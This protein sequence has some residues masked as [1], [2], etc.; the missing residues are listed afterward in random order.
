MQVLLLVL[1]GA[2]SMPIN[3]EEVTTELAITTIAS[4]IDTTLAQDETLETTTVSTSGD[5]HSLESPSQTVEIRLHPQL[6]HTDQLKLTTTEA[7]S[8]TWTTTSAL[9][10]SAEEFK[11]EDIKRETPKGEPYSIF[12]SLSDR[13][14]LK[15]S[16]G[17]ALR[18]A[19]TSSPVVHTLQQLPARSRLGPRPSAAASAKDATP[20]KISSFGALPSNLPSA[21][22]RNRHEKQGSGETPAGTRV[23]TDHE[24][25]Y[26]HRGNINRSV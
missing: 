6:I 23:V 16:I 3:Q 1:C 8:T 25:L 15:D 24:W 9:T 10:T 20:R 18:R 21:L 2:R 11:F 7:E 17:A 22:V 14:R 5:D 4:E 26:G 13:F 12:S 19:I